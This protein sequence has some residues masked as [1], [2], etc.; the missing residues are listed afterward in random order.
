MRHMPLH[1]NQVQY[2]HA[3]VGVHVEEFVKFA[4]L[5]QQDRVAV[6]GFELPPLQGRRRSFSC[7]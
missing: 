1:V 6:L 7:P 5:E 4:R 2:L 3:N